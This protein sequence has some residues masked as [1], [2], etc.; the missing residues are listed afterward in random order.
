MSNLRISLNDFA[1]SRFGSY[2]RILAVK[3]A[4]SG[5]SEIYL[6]T[7]HGDANPGEIFRVEPISNG[8][9]VPISAWATPSVATL[10]S[11]YGQIQLCIS[12]P[13]LLRVK[14]QGLGLR[15]TKIIPQDREY[16]AE[17]AFYYGQNRIQVNARRN[18]MQYMITVLK[19][20]HALVAPWVEISCSTITMEFYPD[21]DT[22][23]MEI[24]LEEFLTSWKARE[25]RESFQDCID[26]VQDDFQGWIKS[27]APAHVISP[28]TLELANF[29]QWSSVIHEHNYLKRTGM[30]MS[31]TN[32]MNVWS[33]DHCFNAMAL[34]YGNPRFA[35]DQ[36]LIPFDHQDDN[37]A[38][39][40]SVNDQRMIW[41]FTKPP[42]HGWTLKWMM[43]RTDA[44]S[45]DDLRDIYPKLARWTDWWF[46]YRDY[47]HNGVPQYNHGNDSGW[48]NS[49]IFCTNAPIESPD[50]SAYLILQLEALHDIAIR[51]GKQDEAKGWMQRAEEKLQQM[52][53]HFWRDDHFVA[54]I[55]GTGEVVDTESLILC[56]PIVM[57]SRLPGRVIDAIADRI[58]T[59]FL[60]EWGLAT[61]AIHSSHYRSDGYWRGP[62]WA[63]STMLI[64][65]GL[66]QAG[67]TEL[68]Q[69]IARRF[70]KM[71]DYNLMAENFDAIT[72]KGL[73]D[74]AYTWTAS[75]L[76]VL[77]HEYCS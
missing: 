22:G 58:E 60:T 68:S 7:V 28:N 37:G 74:P 66:A 50:L 76:L 41:N 71:C 61:E 35:L 72:G 67:K 27:C 47:D 13:G 34:T 59:K 77:A 65:D 64:V 70:C 44:I 14:G 63:P 54:R 12:E 75:V 18:H 53:G 73:R 55:T 42:I 43:N 46:D 48:D 21:P 38:L 11:E 16:T 8:K 39:P 33:W 40:D 49:T 31:K 15:L 69:E 3:D 1:F 62:I 19:G 9:S 57:G 26:I 45:N 10:E 25:Y 32:M 6:S 2:F 4:Q 5:T 30:L 56:L 29:V 23:V 51:I 17:H 24:A 52:L 20:E 36:W